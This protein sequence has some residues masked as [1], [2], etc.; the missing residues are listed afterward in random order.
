MLGFYNVIKPT[1]VS[2]SYVVNKIKHASHAKVGHLGTLDPMASGVLPVAVGNATKFFDYFLKKD[3][4]YVAL[5]KFGVL[6][7]SL[8]ADGEVIES[9]ECNVKLNDVQNVA[10]QLVG[11]IMQVPPAFSAKSVGGVRAYELAR[12]QKEVL[13]PAKKTQIFSINVEKWHQNDV[14]RLKI[15]CSAGTYVRSIVRDI[16]EKLG[17]IAT[18]VAII[19]VA[20]GPFKIEDAAT[21]DEILSNENAGFVKINKVLKLPEIMLESAEAK[22][23]F[24][25]KSI[26]KK[27]PNGDYLTFLGEDEFS[28]AT[29]INGK[30]KNKIYLYEK[31]NIW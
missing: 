24:S 26:D 10:K 14:F 6:T 30:L 9:K 17:T 7:N 25:G 18:C 22:N 20:S 1:G 8:D 27:V 2:S 13:L 4:T 15:H 28:L 5:M 16:A 29:A 31:E 23:L 12:E 21:L 11:E 3:K 19:R